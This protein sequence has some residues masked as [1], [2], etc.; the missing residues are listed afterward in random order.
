MI[1][2]DTCLLLFD[3]TFARPQFEMAITTVK[4]HSIYHPTYLTDLYVM[5]GIL[6]FASALDSA[7]VRAQRFTID[8]IEEWH[9]FPSSPGGV[10]FCLR[11]F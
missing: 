9:H 1:V 5:S 4:R 10:I 3:G 7:V 11:K 8:N 2:A 6:L